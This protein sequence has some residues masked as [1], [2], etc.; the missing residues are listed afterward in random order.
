MTNLNL[1][2]NKEKTQTCRQQSNAKP[3][4]TTSQHNVFTLKII[5]PTK[6]SLHS[7]YLA[8]KFCRIHQG[9]YL[10]QWFQTKRSKLMKFKCSEKFSLSSF[11][12]LLLFSIQL[13]QHATISLKFISPSCMYMHLTPHLAGQANTEGIVAGRLGLRM[14]SEGSIRIWSQTAEKAMCCSTWMKENYSRNHL[15]T[16]WLRGSFGLRFL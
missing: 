15:F 4:S 11:V 12:K 10:P 16:V 13:F 8:T 3:S 7:W 9:A 1:G 2:Q 5:H 6:Y 14:I